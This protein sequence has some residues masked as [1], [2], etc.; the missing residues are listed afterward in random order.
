M[1][2]TG[3]T[4]ERSAGAVIFQAVEESRPIIELE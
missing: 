4:G 2:G 1:D 3:L